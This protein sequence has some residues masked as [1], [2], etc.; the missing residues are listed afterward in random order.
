[1]NIFLD[2]PYSVKLEMFANSVKRHNC[3]VK[4]PLL[5]HD[6]STAVKD[7]VISHLARVLFFAKCFVKIKPSR[8][9]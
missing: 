2:R 5:G 1:M 7:K 8:N 3:H 9:F 6:L 4:N